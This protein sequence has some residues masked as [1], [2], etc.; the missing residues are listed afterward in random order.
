MWVCIGWRSTLQGPKRYHRTTGSAGLHVSGKTTKPPVKVGTKFQLMPESE[1]ILRADD[2]FGPSVERAHWITTC[3]DTADCLLRAAG[4]TLRIRNEHDRFFQNVKSRDAGTGLA[5]S[6][7]E[8]ER[9]VTNGVPEVG[10]LTSVA[11]LSTLELP[12]ADRLTQVF[13]TDIWRIGRLVELRDGALAEVSADTSAAL[14]HGTNRR[15]FARW[16]WS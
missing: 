14:C 12:I 16:N 15:R 3:Y 7:V 8:C 6:H 5:T 11:A 13:V 4:L 10:K 1:A 2:I 9:P